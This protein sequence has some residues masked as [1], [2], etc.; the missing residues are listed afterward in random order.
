MY[1]RLA[2]YLI[3][4]TALTGAYYCARFARAAFLFQRDTADSVAAAVRLVPYNSEYV[5]HFA[6]W[7]PEHRLALFHRAVELNPFDYA[8]WIQLGLAAEI[9]QRDLAS[10]R[11]LLPARG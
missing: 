1:L 7:Q 2:R 9:Q 4:A 8:T 5:A 11:A 3:A 6:A 10:S